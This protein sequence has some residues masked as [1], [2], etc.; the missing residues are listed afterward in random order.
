[1]HVWAINTLHGLNVFVPCGYCSLQPWL[2]RSQ[3][4]I[5]PQL[6]R[7][8]FMRT[9]LWPLPR[10]HVGSCVIRSAGLRGCLHSLQKDGWCG[11]WRIRSLLETRNFIPVLNCCKPHVKSDFLEFQCVAVLYRQAAQE[12]SSAN[13]Q[14]PQTTKKKSKT[15]TRSSWTHKQTTPKPPKND[16]KL[17]KQSPSND[18]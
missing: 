12:K 11:K 18:S 4:V 16:Y 9:Q 13:H 15:W 2:W 8:K 5:F 7:L 14:P 10:H 17:N 3:Y 1:M 6:A